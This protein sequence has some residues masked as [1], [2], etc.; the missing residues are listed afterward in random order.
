MAR[1]I[2]SLLWT[3][4]K[5]AQRPLCKLACNSSS[6]ALDADMPSCSRDLI[7]KHDIVGHSTFSTIPYSIRPFLLPNSDINVLFYLKFTTTTVRCDKS[8]PKLLQGT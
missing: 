4:Y 8:N 1:P 6:L 5:A 3:I 2:L 7:A